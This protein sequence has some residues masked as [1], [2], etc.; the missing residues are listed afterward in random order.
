MTNYI[1]KG[2]NVE[3]TFQ[4]MHKFYSQKDGR[5]LYFDTKKGAKMYIKE[6][7]QEL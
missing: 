1:Y 6:F 2:I 7:W 4:G 5:F 3:I